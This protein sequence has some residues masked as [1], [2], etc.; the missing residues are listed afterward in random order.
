MIKKIAS[1]LLLSL[2][3]QWTGQAQESNTPEERY[4][5][6]E[7]EQRQIDRSKWSELTEGIDYTE[8][9]RRQ[10]QQPDRNNAPNR[11]RNNPMFGEGVGTAIARFLLIA[12]GA[13]A[14]ALLVRSMLGYGRA[15]NKKIKRTTEENIDIQKIEENIHEADLDDFIGRAKSDGNYN[16]AIRLYYLAILKELSLRRDIKWKTDKTNNE[17]LREMRSNEYFPQFREVTRIFE[18]CWYGDRTLSA[19]AFEQLEPDFQQFIERLS[20][21]KTALSS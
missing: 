9:Q 4:L 18:R 3:V 15:K 21:T 6:S 16:L 14:I 7:I 19:A 17:Y 8:R 2:L 12:I 1:I 20:V 10:R 13:I 11:Q 5:D